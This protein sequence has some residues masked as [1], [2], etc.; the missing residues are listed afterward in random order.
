MK[1]RIACYFDVPRPDNKTDD[2]NWVDVRARE[3]RL[4]LQILRPFRLPL[5]ALDPTDPK[6]PPAPRPRLTTTPDRPE[7]HR[8]EE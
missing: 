2:I 5:I 8:H 3:P 4:R 7:A 1:T 6:H